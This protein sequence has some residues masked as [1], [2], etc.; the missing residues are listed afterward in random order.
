MI[1]PK[2][3]NLSLN[4]TTNFNCT[5]TAS[6]IFWRVNEKSISH[7]LRSKGFDDSALTVILNAT[8]NLRT[9]SLSVQGLS[10]NNGSRIACEAYLQITPINY[11]YTKSESARM[12]VQGVSI[13]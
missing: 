9:R 4:K 6:F 7:D 12:L 13:C 10:A 11:D 3:V 5:A 1:S 2:P 8:E